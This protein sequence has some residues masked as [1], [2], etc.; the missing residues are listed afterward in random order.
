MAGLGLVVGAGMYSIAVLTTF[1][2][3]LSLAFLNN[4]EKL[5]KRGVYSNLI[6]IV[7]LPE[8]QVNNILSIFES[9]DLSI[10]KVEIERVDKNTRNIF[11]KI[12]QCPGLNRVAL[13]EE[14]SKN[15]QV[16]NIIERN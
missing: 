10:T 15:D 3:L 2:I 14:I 4:F 16:K 1:V 6:E 8:L 13:F 12:E 7:A 11:I 9:F 5:F